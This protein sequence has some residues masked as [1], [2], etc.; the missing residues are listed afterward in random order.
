MESLYVCRF[1]NGLIKVGRS[2]D[3]E[4]RIASHAD[5]VA[6]MGVELCERFT[7]GCAGHA[8]PAEKDLIACCAGMAAQRFKSEWFAGLAFEDVCAWATRFAGK[9]Y[10]SEFQF[11]GQ[12]SP[13]QRAFAVF[14]SS[15][16]RMA[17]AIGGGVL[18]QSV[19]HWVKSDRIPT[20]HCRSVQE[21]TGVMCWELRPDDWWRIWPDLMDAKG[22]PQVPREP[23]TSES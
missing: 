16:T 17:A 5:R 14:D 20:E 12:Q 1:S 13:V 21:L 11:G 10:E 7:I 8:Q 18:R 6:C 19:E 2:I 9:L 4:S 15:P 23:A 22:A 3:P